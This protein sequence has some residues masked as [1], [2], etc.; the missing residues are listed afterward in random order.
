MIA[1]DVISM[2]DKWAATS[3]LRCDRRTRRL[4]LGC[5]MKR[6][7]HSDRDD[8]YEAPDDCPSTRPDGIQM[9]AQDW[10]QSFARAVTVA[11]SGDTG[12]SADPN[13]PFLILINSWWRPLDFTVPDSLRDLGWQ[14]EID[15][16]DPKT[17]ALE[18]RRVPLS[19]ARERRLAL[20]H[21][22]RLDVACAG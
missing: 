6:H 10:N 15:T 13:D 3:R 12:D 18:H 7:S 2:P 22:A 5:G 20:D 16:R 8:A 17:A 1:R 21:G 14:V 9:T 4:K 19:S 11:L